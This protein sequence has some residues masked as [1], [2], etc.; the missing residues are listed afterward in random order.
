MKSPTDMGWKVS[1]SSKS[2]QG[3]PGWKLMEYADDD[4]GDLLAN[5]INGILHHMSFGK[6]FYWQYLTSIQ[7]MHNIKYAENVI[8]F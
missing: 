3:N 8:S 4:A 6:L 2:V 1:N 7:E 5:K